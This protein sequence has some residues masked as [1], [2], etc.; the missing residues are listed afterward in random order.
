MWS[1][2]MKAPNQNITFW[3][4]SLKSCNSWCLLSSVP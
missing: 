2:M 3:K 4:W 1:P